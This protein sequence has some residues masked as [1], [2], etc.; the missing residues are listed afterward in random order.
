MECKVRHEKFRWALF[1]QF[2]RPVNSAGRGRDV[3]HGGQGDRG[4]TCL[5]RKSAF[6]LA[7]HLAPFPIPADCTAVSQDCAI[8]AGATCAPWKSRDAPRTRERVK[9]DKKERDRI[10][11]TGVKT[12]DKVAMSRDNIG[13]CLLFHKT[14]V[15]FARG[16][17]LIR[18]FVSPSFRHLDV[19]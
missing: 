2:V 17:S 1:G 14:R 9:A 18:N 11:G 6:P 12:N 19:P 5:E 13:I 16:G 10:I 7:S 8:H 15:L 4:L 3:I